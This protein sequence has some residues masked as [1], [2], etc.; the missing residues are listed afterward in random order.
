MANIVD[1]HFIANMNF[2]ITFLCFAL[3]ALFVPEMT[4]RKL[5]SSRNEARKLKR[6]VT[7]LMKKR[8]IEQQAEQR[9]LE[10]QRERKVKSRLKKFREQIKIR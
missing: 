7:A 10:E 9:R 8:M 2:K 6:R 1:S 5:S 3:C 4:K